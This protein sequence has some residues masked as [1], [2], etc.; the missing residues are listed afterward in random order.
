MG[1]LRQLMRLLVFLTGFLRTDA[2]PGKWTRLVLSLVLFVVLIG[3]YLGGAYHRHR[4]NPQD[5]IMPLPS[6]MVEGV[7]NV[8]F[9]EDRKGDLRLWV[10]TWAS[11]KRFGIAIAIGVDATGCSYS[12]A[13]LPKPNTDTEYQPR[14]RTPIRIPS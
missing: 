8:A 12:S 10:D 5:K 1:F 3:A 7:K 13:I 11:T 4:E 2:R 9:K 14:Y 6:K